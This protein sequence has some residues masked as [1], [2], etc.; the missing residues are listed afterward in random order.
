MEGVVLGFIDILEAARIRTLRLVLSTHWLREA[1]RDRAIRLALLFS[2]CVFIYLP[3]SLYFPLWILAVGPVVWGIPHIFASLRFQTD[4]VIAETPQN[5]SKT[6]RA[7]I[8]YSCSVWA[9]IALFRIYTDVFQKLSVWDRTHPG[10]VEASFAIFLFS[11]LVYIFRRNCKQL[12]WGS[13][14]LVPV[15]LALW[16]LPLVFAGILILAHNFIACI[17]WIL[18][19]RQSRDRA[20]AVGATA[21]FF[22]IHVLVFMKA[23]DRAINLYPVASQLGWSGASV[24]GLGHMI[25]PWSDDL[26]V[27]YRAVC[28]YAFGQSLHYF[29][30]L[31]AIPDLRA[32]TS[33]PT[34]FRTA[35]NFL[36]RDFGFKLGIGAIVLSLAPVAAWLM[37]NFEVSHNLYFAFASCHG[38]FEFAGLA[39]LAGKAVGRQ[40]KTSV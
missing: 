8:F 15:T 13:I 27:W 6:V 19:A 22:L 7:A 10:V 40:K 14:V 1:F 26:S 29:I 25:V 17:F 23:F 32:P 9:G 11:G 31:K 3:L 38:Y 37:L 39:L 33:N 35:W 5:K 28:L 20:V 2:L 24:D 4:L 30:W 18:A 21:I 12:L 34:S 16:K 36:K